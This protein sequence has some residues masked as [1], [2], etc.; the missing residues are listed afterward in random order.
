MTTPDAVVGSAAENDPVDPLSAERVHDGVRPAPSLLRNAAHMMSSQVLTWVL[1]TAVQVMIPT[2]LGPA[3]LGQLRLA[4]AVWAMG[5]IFVALGTNRYLRLEVARDPERGLSLVGPIIA[6]R[7]V[8]FAVLSVVLAIVG[9][10][11]GV[12]GATAVV[13]A[14]IGVHVLIDTVTETWGSALV[15]LEEVPITARVAIIAKLAYTVVV[16]GVLLAGGGP[17]AVAATAIVGS[18]VAITMLHRGFRRFGSTDF[19]NALARGWPVVRASLAFLAMAATLVVYQQVDMIVLSTLVDSVS[20]GWY[21]TA[22]TLFGTMLFLPVIT[23]TVIL[24]RLGRLHKQDPAELHRLGR[25]AF[26]A[27]A[28]IAV[29]IGLGAMVISNRLVLTLFGEEFRESGPVLAVYGIVL[30][31]TCGTILIG[32]IASATERARLWNYVMVAAIA[33]SIPLDIVLVPWTDRRFDNGA[34]GGALAY[35]VTELGILLA[36]LRWFAPFLITRATMMRLCKTLL[37]G[38][39]MVAA[40]WPLRDSLFLAIPVGAVVYAGAVLALRTLDEQEQASLRS[41]LHRLRR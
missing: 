20:L 30:V 11:G 3:G 5:N 25:R 10:I 23:I 40:T 1:A 6:V 18:V 37:A 13:F 15:G 7:L 9:T 12:S 41:G 21:S 19:T 36:G 2:F 4:T 27:Q 22:D 16:V 29:P 17:A 14:V 33:V 31:F 34:I 28:L 26:A 38:A 35:I 32:G 39:A 24:P 8:A